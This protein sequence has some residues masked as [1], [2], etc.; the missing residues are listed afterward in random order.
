MSERKRKQILAAILCATTMTAFYGVPR[1][2]AERKVYDLVDYDTDSGKLV[3]ETNGAPVGTVGTTIE[4]LDLGTGTLT[5]ASV[6]VGSTIIDATYLGKI[7]AT[8][9]GDKMVD[10]SGG[11]TLGAADVTTTGTVTGG[12][13]TDGT[14]TMTGG[15]LTGLTS[16]SAD[17]LK[18]KTL[19]VGN[20]NTEFTVDGDGA[21]SAA[22]GEVIISA[23]GETK[24]GSETNNNT[25]INKGS[26]TVK[27]TADTKD[28]TT[29]NGG[30]V[31]A[32]SAVNVGNNTKITDGQA[33]FGTTDNNVTVADQTI[34]V[35]NGTN[36]STEIGAGSVLYKNNSGAETS[37]GGNGI[38]SVQGDN[39]FSFAAA[40]GTVTMKTAAGYTTVT[41][42][43]IDVYNGNG[44]VAATSIEGDTITTGTLKTDKLILGK[45]DT[46][47]TGHIELGA[48][49]S[50]KAANDSF[51]VDK[52]GVT[53][54]GADVNNVTTIDGGKLSSTAT[55]GN[56]KNSINSDAKNYSI[57][58]SETGSTTAKLEMNNG[59]ITNSVGSND[60]HSFTEVTQNNVTLISTANGKTA[61]TEISADGIVDRVSGANGSTSVVTTG[62]G[63][64][65]KADGDLAG[66][67]SFNFNTKTGIGTFTGLDETTTTLNGS[68]V[69]SNDAAG[70]TGVLNGS[71]LTLTN[72]ADKTEL[73]AGGASFTGATGASTKAGKVTTID[74]GTITTDTLKVERI[75][76]G[77]T[78][79][80]ATGKPMGGNLTLNADGSLTA[81]GGNFAV[82]GGTGADKGA[83]YNQVGN[84]TFT[85]S[86]AGVQAMVSENDGQYYGKTNVELD[87]V[88]TE[89]KGENG[90]ATS[91]VTDSSITNNVGTATS[92]VT[93]GKI[94]DTV[95]DA[96]VTTTT[97][98]TVFESKNQNTP[99]V[100]GGATNTTINGNTITTGQITTDKLVITG[101]GDADGTG[102]GSIAMGGDGTIVS[103]IKDGDKDTHF[104]TTVDGINGK[105]TDGTNTTTTNTAADG[106]TTTVTDGA[107]T[108]SSGVSADEIKNKVNDN[109][110]TVGTEGITSAA[111]T[112]S[113]KLTQ[114]GGFVVKQDGQTDVTVNKGD[115]TITDKNGNG[116]Q[117]SDIGYKGDIDSELQAREEYKN[118]ETVVGGLN[119]EAGIRREEVAR[120]DNRID[121]TNERLDRVGAMAAAAASLKS[122]GYDP[123]A[124]T[125]FAMGLGTYKGSQAVAIGLF[126]Y[127]NRDFML[128][129]NYT[130][131]GSERMGGVGATWK[132]GRKNPDKVLD[133]QLKERQRKVQNAQEKAEAAKKLAQEAS[134]RAGYAAKQAERAKMEAATATRDVEKAYEDKEA[135]D[136]YKARQAQ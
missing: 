15:N 127:P 78:M 126:H 24:F 3:L 111:G 51:N 53:T 99:F 131:S 84:T 136:E 60:V 115:I 55:D 65:V 32:G 118:N 117:M 90:T 45:G 49:G 4:N 44:T 89:V 103:D 50:L 37:I 80:D 27:A 98:G 11:L 25:V 95:G 68:V 123:A 39:A 56:S 26:I 20:N 34:T 21:V 38:N 72:G 35:K 129:I 59:Q 16:L 74:G 75:E 102:S 31:T 105:V 94:T 135:Y 64:T 18:A 12:I 43:A 40:T 54:I 122:M 119:A 23:G 48:D 132:F 17:E 61:T 36:S 86:T 57:T 81:A 91:T 6:S 114:D 109:S 130:Q 62:E 67:A 7:N 87:S 92:T 96:S 104:A 116:I 28:Q 41:G 97:N 30:N 70:T 2:E 88:T 52:N 33:V 128:N 63:F 73:T 82:T 58:L 66:K 133:E 77:E 85:T 134:E 101:N 1:A 5:V 76:L 83:F 113:T 8:V 9:T 112:T 29:I 14:A 69:T 121:D 46:E 124:P 110:V 22:K 120:L 71:N 107:N 13:I 100:E 108:A 42:N 10:A 79:V 125:E 19:S 106:T 47:G 93:D